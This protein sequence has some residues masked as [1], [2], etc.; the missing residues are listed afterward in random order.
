ML[1]AG[2]MIRRLARLIGLTLLG[3]WL[4]RRSPITAAFLRLGLVVLVFG[5]PLVAVGSG[6]MTYS[7]VWWWLWID[8]AIVGIWVVVMMRAQSVS[9]SLITFMVVHYFVMFTLV[10]AVLY[11]VYMVPRLPLSQQPWGL[12]VLALASFVLHGWGTRRGWWNPHG[13]PT[14]PAWRHPRRA[15]RLSLVPYLRLAVVYVGVFL[16]LALGHLDR[17]MPATPEDVMRTAV[18]LV[19]IKL[20]LELVLATVHLVRVASRL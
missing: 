18:L 20:G 15:L 17:P 12:V 3:S 1:H 16:P 5:S 11:A 19:W 2:L 6:T 14:P 9:P 8:A 13:E 7:D 4:E 10:P